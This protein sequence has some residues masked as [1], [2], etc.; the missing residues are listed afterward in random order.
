M[1]DKARDFK[2]NRFILMLRL[3]SFVTKG[4]CDVLYL[5]CLDRNRDPKKT[6]CSIE[7][8]DYSLRT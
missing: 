6:G 8:A 5:R 7:V 2:L 1:L 4:C 3:L